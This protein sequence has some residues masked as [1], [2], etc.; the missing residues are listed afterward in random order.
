MIVTAIRA[1]LC[2]ADQLYVRNRRS[3]GKLWVE[4]KPLMEALDLPQQ[5]DDQVGYLIG[6]RETQPQWRRALAKST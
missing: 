5:G 3:D 2:H 4:Q 6:C 1:Y